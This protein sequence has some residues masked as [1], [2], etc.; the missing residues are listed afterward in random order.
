MASRQPD[1][2]VARYR[3]HA[4]RPFSNRPNTSG[5]NP[6][7]ALIRCPPASSISIRPL[8]RIGPE[9]CSSRVVP[10]EQ[11]MI[12]SRNQDTGKVE[13][14]APQIETFGATFDRILETC[15]DIRPPN[16]FIAEEQIEALLKSKNL[17]DVEAGFHELVF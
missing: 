11:V 13:V 8:E 1:P 6:P 14:V 2:R 15:F 7:S 12:F 3:D 9:F 16:S 17:A 4:I 5:S 10:R